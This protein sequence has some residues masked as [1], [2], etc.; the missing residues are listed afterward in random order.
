M[1]ALGLVQVVVPFLLITF[2]ENH[3]PSSLAAILVASVADLSRRCS[4]CASTTTS[5]R[6][7]GRCVGVVIGIV[8]VVLLF[9][10][11][12]SGDAER[13][14]RRRDDAR[15]GALLRDLVAAGQARVRRRG[16]RGDRGGTMFVAAVVTAPLLVASPPAAAPA[17]DSVASLSRSA[18]A[19]PGSRSSSSTR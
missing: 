11:D 4:R 17:L 1:V 14:R 15:R 13:A 12:L 16:A 5:A 8:G 2:G 10:V 3:I 19:G 18:S 6:A 9:G 7:A